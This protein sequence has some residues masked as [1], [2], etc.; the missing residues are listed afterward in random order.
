MEK[1]WNANLNRTYK[2]DFEVYDRSQYYENQ[3]LYNKELYSADVYIG[4]K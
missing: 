4:I 1:N 2:A 3:K